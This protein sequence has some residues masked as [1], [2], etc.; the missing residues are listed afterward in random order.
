MESDEEDRFVVSTIIMRYLTRLLIK[1]ESPRVNDGAV[2]ASDWE[3]VEP[4]AMVLIDPLPSNSTVRA[5]LSGSKAE[6]SE[7]STELERPEYGKKWTRATSRVVY[8]CIL[9]TV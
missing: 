6:E 2:D 1:E 9:D 4:S 3:I 7:G 8:C 5:L